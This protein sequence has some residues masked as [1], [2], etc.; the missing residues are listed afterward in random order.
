MGV[1]IS[2][3]VFG[4]P[5]CPNTG[6]SPGYPAGPGN[7]NTWSRTRTLT[8]LNPTRLKQYTQKLHSNTN[9]TQPTSKGVQDTCPAQSWR[10]APLQG[11][12]PILALGGGYPLPW[13]PCPSSEAPMYQRPPR[14]L[15]RPPITAL[16]APNARRALPPRYNTG[17][18]PCS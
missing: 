16:D 12:C 5:P 2:S 17:P 11:M 6:G 14:V 15:S 13:V 7:S 10:Q 18:S 8:Q 4:T 3:S 9:S 1:S